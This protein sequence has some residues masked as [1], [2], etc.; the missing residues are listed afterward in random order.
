MGCAILASTA[1]LVVRYL[2][3]R[4]FPLEEYLILFATICFITETALAYSFIPSMYLID[5]ATLQLPVLRHIILS[6]KDS[7]AYELQ[8]A[9]F[10]TN[11]KPVNAYFVLGWL[12]IF[13]V[14][15][16]VLSLFHGM[17]RD[18]TK[19]LVIWFWITVAFTA[20][21]ALIA[22]LEA[23]V[24]CTQFGAGPMRCFI[25]DSYTVSIQSGVVAQLLD[26]ATNF[27]GTLY[28]PFHGVVLH[29]ANYNLSYF[30]SSS[31]DAYVQITSAAQTSIGLC[32]LSIG[33]VHSHRHHPYGWRIILEHFW[34]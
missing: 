27:M 4:T 14:K 15:A 7:P 12:V 1:R 22:V 32:H 6:V 21:S 23:F 5:A 29:C 26:I 9:L 11:T 20:S 16:S 19:L 31:D 17:L 24:L 25:E 2:R 33:S 3:E 34:E 28:S 10:D 8:R 18:A 30:D 13:S